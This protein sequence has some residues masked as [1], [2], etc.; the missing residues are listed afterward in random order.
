MKC[1]SS[2]KKKKE[3][4]L[5]AATNSEISQR[6]ILYNIT[7]IK[8]L[9]NNSNECICKAET[10]RYRKQISGDRRGGVGKGPV[11]DVGLRTANN[12]V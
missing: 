8:S 12:Y 7:Y 1:Y 2:K 3:I 11:R 9:K 6:Q 4:L 5:L 10:D